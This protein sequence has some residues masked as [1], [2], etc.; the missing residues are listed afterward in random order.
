MRYEPPKIVRREAVS[1]LLDA[2]RSDKKV[3]SDVRLKEHVVPVVW[4]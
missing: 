3:I 2:V 4:R 1:A